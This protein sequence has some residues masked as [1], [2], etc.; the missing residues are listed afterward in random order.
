[1]QSPTT[2]EATD[3]L[4]AM[5]AYIKTESPGFWNTLL[6]P[7]A[8]DK[9]A[10]PAAAEPSDGMSWY[11]TPVPDERH[12]SAAKRALTSETAKRA[13][14]D[15]TAL[16]TLPDSVVEYDLAQ[17]RPEDLSRL[18]RLLG[19][20]LARVGQPLAPAAYPA[21]L[22]MRL[23][24]VT[25]TPATTM[26]MQATP[27][28]AAAPVAPPKPPVALDT[29]KWVDFP[30]EK[31]TEINHNTLRLRFKLPTTNLG[32]PVGK[33][34][35][36]KARIDG[37]PVMRAYTPVGH[38]PGYV[39]FVIK[40]YFPLPP[41]FPEGGKL[42]QHMHAMALGDCLG[43]KGPLGEIDFDCNFDAPGAPS[44][45][46]T[47]VSF[48]VRGASRGTS[49]HKR[50]GSDAISDK[51]TH[52]STPPSP[53]PHGNPRLP[54][55]TP[56]PPHVRG[57]RT[58]RRQTRRLNEAHWLHRRRLGHHALPAGGRPSRPNNPDRKSRPNVNPEAVSALRLGHTAHRTQKH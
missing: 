47:P 36:L 50:T 46:D 17:L 1:M 54:P 37:K 45:R 41:R 48:L 39:E 44:P 7:A 57:R 52:S 24:V 11:L 38:G 27:A 30:L 33:H 58:A 32:L 43:F 56:C 2:D 4:A 28:A 49:D 23:P 9:T 15:L 25:S 18:A 26:A 51:L 40:V 12:E 8:K 10:P 53:S 3:V 20:A 14:A 5:Q 29:K 34:I 21:S 19:A 13:A 16:L 6:S 55:V 42:T 31:R 22:L 35:F